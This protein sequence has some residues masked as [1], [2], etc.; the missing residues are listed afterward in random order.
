MNAD[1]R[2]DGCLE[3]IRESRAIYQNDSRAKCDPSV[4]ALSRG[5][6]MPLQELDVEVF[7]E[8]QQGCWVPQQATAKGLEVLAS[9][10]LAYSSAI[11]VAC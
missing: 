9:M 1:V 7:E 6:V 5:L 3:V 4:K 8:Q 11:A 2:G 10:T